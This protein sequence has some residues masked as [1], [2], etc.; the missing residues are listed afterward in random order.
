MGPSAFMPM[1][2]PAEGDSLPQGK[3]AAFDDAP[4]A[5]GYGSCDA[6]SMGYVEVERLQILQ[7]GIAGKDE[8]GGEVLCR[9]GRE[10]GRKRLGT[11]EPV[12]YI[13]IVHAASIESVDQGPSQP[14][15]QLARCRRP[16][17]SSVGDYEI[18]SMPVVPERFEMHRAHFII[19]IYLK[20]PRGVGIFAVSL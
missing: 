1:Q 17:A 3:K 11:H 18:I 10:T 4:V 19:R 5:S 7:G 16:A 9:D 6:A 12:G 15:Q 2:D 13:D 14:A 8:V 20:E